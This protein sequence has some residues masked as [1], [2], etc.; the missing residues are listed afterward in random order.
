MVIY[1]SMIVEMILTDRIRLFVL[2]LTEA[3]ALTTIDYRIFTGDCKLFFAS[4]VDE[5]WPKIE[6]LK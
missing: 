5:R 2:C 4:L 6:Q 3:I 1:V